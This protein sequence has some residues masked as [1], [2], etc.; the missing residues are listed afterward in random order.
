[1]RNYRFLKSG[2]SW[3]LMLLILTSCTFLA[4]PTVKTHFSSRQ[5][6]ISRHP[7]LGE[8]IKQAI[9][10]AKVIKGMTKNEILATWGNPDRVSNHS[11]DPRWFEKGEEDWEYDRLLAIPIHVNIQDGIVESV[12]DSLK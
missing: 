5:E 1:M 2:M 12:N 6:Y 4:R 9:L 3:V 11:T 10:G 8:E 7:E